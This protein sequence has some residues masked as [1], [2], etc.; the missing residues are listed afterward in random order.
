MVANVWADKSTVTTATLKRMV[1]ELGGYAM[2]WDVGVRGY[3]RNPETHMV[4]IP[5]FMAQDKET[6]VERSRSK[7]TRPL[8]T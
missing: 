4:M 3:H 5:T 7:R 8:S 2:Q 6:P 1:V